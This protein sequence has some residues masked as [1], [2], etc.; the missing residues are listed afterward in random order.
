MVIFAQ[1]P[2]SIYFLLQYKSNLW[3]SG[4]R[5]ER[6]KIK[7]KKGKTTTTKKKS[8]L[9]ERYYSRYNASFKKSISPDA[10]I[11]VYLFD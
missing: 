7:K 11:I 8:T 2:S 5:G 1:L 4:E 3:Y 10:N 6:K 9:N